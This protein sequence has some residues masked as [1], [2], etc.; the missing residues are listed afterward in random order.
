MGNNCIAYP[1]A[2]GEKKHYLLAKKECLS[3]R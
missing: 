3:H 1:I 2:Y